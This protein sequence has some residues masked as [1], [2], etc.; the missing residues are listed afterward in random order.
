MDA[1]KTSP[2]TKGP[3]NAYRARRSAAAM[4]VRTVSATLKPVFANLHRPAPRVAVTHLPSNAISSPGDASRSTV[5]PIAVARVASSVTKPV[6]S[7]SRAVDRRTVRVPAISF[8]SRTPRTTIAVNAHRPVNPTVIALSV[9][10]ATSANPLR[11]AAWKSPAQRNPTAVRERSVK[12]AAAASSSARRTVTVRPDESATRHSTDVSAVTAKT[13][14]LP[15]IIRWPPRPHSTRVA[16]Q[17]SN[18]AP[19]GMTGT[20]SRWRQTNHSSSA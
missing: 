6:V 20:A 4:A 9:S 3:V 11:G 8:V 15:Q 1:P 16:I 17:T 14:F 7:V 18:C 10:T 13:I 5:R 19:A 12:T 2:A